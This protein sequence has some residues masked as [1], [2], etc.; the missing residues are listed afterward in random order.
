MAL[1]CYLAV[2]GDN[3]SRDKLATLLWPDSDQR[4]ARAGLRSAL[5]DLNKTPLAS[6]LV[7]EPETISLSPKA[8][9]LWLDVAHFR[10][11]LAA[12]QSHDHP[13]S[14]VCSFCLDQLT[15]A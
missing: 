15:E 14:K 4:R 10:Q 6:W 8:E 3:H 1:L 5:W 7:V 9:E 13:T 12:V 11:N 2:T